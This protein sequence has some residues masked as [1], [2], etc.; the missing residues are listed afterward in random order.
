MPKIFP[1]KMQMRRLRALI[2]CDS[3]ALTPS[4][5]ISGQR[6]RVI[7][8]LNAA[9]ITFNYAKPQTIC[10]FVFDMQRQHRRRSCIICEL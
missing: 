10:R 8:A 7:R 3:S 4:A 5:S 6:S 9:G 1:L 2:S